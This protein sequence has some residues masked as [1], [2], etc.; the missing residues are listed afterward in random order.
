MYL[1]AVITIKSQHF[2]YTTA[3]LRYGRICHILQADLVCFKMQVNSITYICFM[4]VAVVVIILAGY[5][6]FFKALPFFF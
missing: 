3:Y 1:S 5:G 6:T 2:V 4:I